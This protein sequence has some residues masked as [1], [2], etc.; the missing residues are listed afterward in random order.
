MGGANETINQYKSISVRLYLERSS[1]FDRVYRARFFLGTFH[2]VQLR[3][4]QRLCAK[5]PAVELPHLEVS[6][7]SSAENSSVRRFR[8]SSYQP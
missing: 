1:R 4:R 3:G 6:V 2:P 5:V 7:L 8:L